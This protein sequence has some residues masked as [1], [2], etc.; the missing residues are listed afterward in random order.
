MRELRLVFGAT[1]AATA[2]VLAMFMAGLGVGSAVLGKRADQVANPLRM[3]GLLEAAIAISVAATPWLIAL[4][5]SVYIGLGGQESLGLTG[6]TAVRL[7]LAAAVMAVP[8]FLMGGTLPAAV[9]AVTRTT[10]AH[11]GAL[12]VLYGAN[13]LGAVF[14]AAAATFFALEYLGTRA[15]LWT[16]CAIGLLAG[17]IAVAWSRRL[18]PLPMREDHSHA[19]ASANDPAKSSAPL[20]D[21]AL[22]GLR[23]GI[24]YLTAAVLGFTFFALEIVWYRMLAPI[25]GGT[26]F[27]FGLI[28]C[29]ALLGIGIGGIAYNVVFRRLRPTW[30]ALAITCG[31]EAVFTIL[32]FALGDRLAVLAAWRSQSATSFSELVVGWAYVAGIVVVPVALVSGLQFP[33]LTALLG[34]GRHTVSKHLGMTYAWNTL[35]AISG[36]LVAGFGGLPWLGA[37]G[38]WQTIAV[39]LSVLSVGI[40]IGSPAR[41]RRTVAVVASLA[42]VTFGSMFARGPTAAW[43]HGG[44]GAGRAVLPESDPN[45]LQQW[46]NEKRHILE[47]ETDGIESSVGITREDGLVFV[48]SGK[49]DGNALND[50]PTQMGAAILGAVLHKNPRTALVIGLGTGESAGWL[51]D[52]RNVERVDVVELEPAIDEM[53]RRCRELNRDVLNHPRVRRIYNDGREFVLTTD[54]KYDVVISEPSNPYRAGI[55][56]LYTTEFYEAVRE[57]LNPGGLFIQW[58]QAYEVDATTV[59]SVL[60]TAR[61]S[62]GH[63]ELWQTLPVDLQLVCSASPPEYTADQLRGRIASG[64]VKEALAKAWKVNDL[65]GLLARFVANR[66]WAEEVVETPF[67]PRNTDDRTILEYRFAKTVGRTAPFSVEEIRSRLQAVGYHRPPLD[68]ESLDWNRVEVRRQ[69]FNLLFN[70]LLSVALL[71]RPEDRALVE[72]FFDYHKQE[73]ARALARWPDEYLPPKSDI[74]RLI[75]ASC[76][77]ELARAECLDLIAAAEEQFAIEAAALRAT[78][79]WRSG[80]TAQTRES[81]EA[82]LSLLAERPWVITIIAEPALSLALD[83]AQ[84]DPD[85]ARRFYVLLSKPFASYRFDYARQLALV[86]VAQELEPKHVV[87]ALAE[88]EPHIPWTTEILQARTKAYAAVNHPLA[89]RAERDWHWYQRHEPAKKAE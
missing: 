75:L 74:Q 34:Q 35:G 12:G 61:S 52:I 23:P 72:A 5:S 57:R 59:N 37:L 14:G 39:V 70:S 49:S 2:A 18:T 83:V 78:Y 16:G 10:D 26:A 24:V 32:P 55:A 89:K 13:T 56:A 53:A 9:R 66:R 77:A 20:E 36:S 60:A 40:L 67:V 19:G 25:L 4:A 71:P 28:L 30:S 80:N 82:F 46:I 7:A 44:V 73:F 50:A 29:L 48:V 68:D 84:A 88:L 3:Y 38:M 22:P 81:L 54:S 31:C 69:E 15:T 45:R 64:V 51:A 85:A 1:T 86:A 65:E 11:R 42:V 27:T 17:T 58:L 47:W 6:A 43:R 62:F 8:T 41:D 33:L 79:Y 21:D 87:E 76:Y 63:V